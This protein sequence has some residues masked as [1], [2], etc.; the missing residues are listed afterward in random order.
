MNR[1]ARVV[2]SRIWRRTWCASR[3]WT[4]SCAPTAAV[5]TTFAPISCEIDV[6]P[7]AHGAALFTRGETQAFALTTLGSESDELRVLDAL[8][9]D[10]DTRKGFMLHYNFPPFSVGETGR[11]GTG[12]REVGHG[13]LA[14]RA[15]E[16]MIPSK[17][18]FP[19]T[20]RLVSEI[21]ESNGSSSMASVCGGTL[22]LLNAGVPIKKSVAGIAMGLVTD[23]SRHVVISDILG[24]E[25]HLGDMDFKVAGT[26]DGITAF[27]MDIKVAGVDQSVLRQAL[28]K[29]KAG[30]L[31][32]LEIMAATIGR[33][34][35]RDLRSRPQD[36]VHVDPGGQDRGSD[37]SRRRQHP[38]HHR[39]ER[40]GREYP[41]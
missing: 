7:R 12:R 4:Y 29:A 19:Y 11:L 1:T 35:R 36:H 14:E 18:E 39:A 13:H 28:D 40:G 6:L 25:D 37:W 34:T 2:C 9:N 8:E 15:L 16:G 41:R 17:E 31:K 32:I 21:L 20:I 38:L 26:S 30:R 27:Q 24:E 23:G 33:S 3:F 10:Q 22:S 5:P